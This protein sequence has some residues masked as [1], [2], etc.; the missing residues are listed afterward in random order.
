MVVFGYAWGGPIGLGLAG[1]RPELVRA[2]V[3]ANTWAWPDDRLRVRLFSA[4]MGG[5]L[6]PLLVDR[7]NLMLRVYLPF[8]LK[9]GAPDRCGAGRLCGSVPAREAI[10]HGRL[11][12]RDHPRSRL[13]ARGR[14]EPAE[15]RR[16]SPP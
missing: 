1:R 2:L 3:I 16:P 14:G 6:S 10:D 4:L 13:A 9:R 7:L 15:A 11:P 12:A 5:P 8:N